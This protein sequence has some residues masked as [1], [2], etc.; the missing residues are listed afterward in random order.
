M[1]TISIIL[2]DSIYMRLK[3]IVPNR[4]VSKFVAEAIEEKLEDK[5]GALLSAYKE[6]YADTAREK[7]AKIWDVVDGENWD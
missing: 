7:E 4:K 2:N 5:T 1:Q 6:A 3:Q